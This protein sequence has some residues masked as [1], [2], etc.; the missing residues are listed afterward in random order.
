[1]SAWILTQRYMFVLL[2][3]CRAIQSSVTARPSVPR[4]APTSA[5]MRSASSASVPTA[6][7]SSPSRCRRRSQVKRDT[8]RVDRVQVVQ[9]RRTLV[10][11]GFRTPYSGAENRTAYTGTETGSGRHTLIQGRVQN[12]AD[13]YMTCTGCHIP[14]QRIRQRTLVQGHVVQDG[15]HRYR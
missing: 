15:M 7:S 3:R 4:T 14:V 5:A 12:G 6:R 11:A 10:Q 8:P 13:W 2:Q 9:G 1:M